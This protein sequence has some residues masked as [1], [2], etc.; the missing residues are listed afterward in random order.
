M[1]RYYES[2]RHPGTYVLDLCRMDLRLGPSLA[3]IDDYLNTI[4]E[5]KNKIRKLVVHKDEKM[6]VDTKGVGKFLTMF[7]FSQDNAIYMVHSG[8]NKKLSHLLKTMKI[9]HILEPTYQTL[10][11]ALEELH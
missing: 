6:G 7:K 11:E 4:L 1:E 8:T 9:K 10:E 5:D 2:S 3:L